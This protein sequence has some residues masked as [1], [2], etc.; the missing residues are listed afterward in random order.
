MARDAGAFAVLTFTGETKRADVDACAPID[1]PDRVVA[2]LG[3]LA[4]L[5]KD[6]RDAG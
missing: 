2:D 5:I 4:R 3:E 1:R 6:A